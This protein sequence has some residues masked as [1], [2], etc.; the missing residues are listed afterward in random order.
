[1]TYLKILVVIGI[2]LTFHLINLRPV[3]SSRNYIVK[4]D[5]Y[6]SPEEKDYKLTT[7]D[8][9]RSLFTKKGAGEQVC[10]G[11]KRGEQ[12]DV[13]G[14]GFELMNTSNG[15]LLTIGYS[16]GTWVSESVTKPS[17]LWFQMIVEIF[18]VILMTYVLFSKEEKTLDI[19]RG[20]YLENQNV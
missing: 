10:Y 9:M 1:M 11:V 13:Y 4:K 19:S 8:L 2:A 6:W 15:L 5:S 20:V 7:Y 17:D 14:G 12:Y 18:M 16:Q 3:V